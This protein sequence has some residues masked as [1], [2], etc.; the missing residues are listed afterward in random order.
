[1]SI[2]LVT[3]VALAL[4][5]LIATVLPVHMGV[6]AFV[7]AFIVGTAFAGE[8]TDD[9][10]AGFPGD[11]FIILVGVTLLFAIAKGNG[12]VD[13]LVQAAVRAVRG[14]IALIPWVMFLVTGA[15]TAVGAVV[16]AAVAIIA[17]IGMGFATRYRI[18]PM[19]MGLLIINGASAGGF[20]PMSIFGS[21]VNGVVG[22][23]ALPSNP[24]LLFLSSFLFN[25]ALS[26]VVFF[27]FGGRELLKRQASAISLAPARDQADTVRV[28]AG[29][30]GSGGAG[31]APDEPGPAS[32]ASDA[33]SGTG[34]GSRDETDEKPA[35]LTRDHVLTLLG[36]AALAVG[37]LAFG[38]DVGVTA[39]TVAALLSLASPAS[40]KAAVAQVAWP[41][42]LLICGI[43]T[44]VS[45]MERGRHDRLARPHGHDDRL[46][47]SGCDHHLPHR[48]CRLR[49]RLDH[50]HPRGSHP[51]RRTVPAGRP[52]RR[53]R[54]DHRAVDL[55]VGGGLVSLLDQRRAR[56]RQRA[57][58]RA[59]AGLPRTD[60][61]GLQ[62]V[63][64]RSDRDVADLR[65]PGMV[66]AARPGGAARIPEPRRGL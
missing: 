12:T 3:I 65:R 34:P 32:P 9:V 47:P 5:F 10:L 64:R 27:L 51:A 45:L 53:G 6:L 29:V 61:V 41:T 56:R 49:V 4:V 42:V 21:I 40:A 14:R 63:R 2:Q 66:I 50:G 62:H 54:P 26:V 35:P 23:N 16:P 57:G 43:V 36:L 19:L 8:S 1:M 11:L 22:R 48:C 31:A 55:G 52:D 18:N 60:G 30:P 37:A 20:S 17:P 38:L 46:A 24:G 7:A 44:F 28:G 58:R 39:L 25:L 33:P 59:R 13:W 15:L